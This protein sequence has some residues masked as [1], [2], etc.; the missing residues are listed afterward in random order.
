MVFFWDRLVAPIFLV[1]DDEKN[2]AKK[3]N[4]LLATAILFHSSPG[5]LPSPCGSSLRCLRS[6]PIRT[7]FHMMS[8]IGDAKK[9]DELMILS[10]YENNGTP[11]PK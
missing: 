9:G 1:I 8:F 2:S 5:R 6:T 10:T 3:R 4:E 7:G 11:C